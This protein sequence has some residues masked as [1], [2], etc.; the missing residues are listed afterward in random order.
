[1]G[2]AK[3]TDDSRESLTQAG[4]VFGTPEYL[5]PE[6]AMGEEADGRADLYAAGVILYEMLTGNRPYEA[7]SRVEI[8]SMHL[9]RPIPSLPASLRSL[10]RVV[11]QAMAKKRDQRY[12]SA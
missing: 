7:E 11:Q 9:T 3:I 4:V 8:V 12:A 10:E 1:F 2:I 5:S 6:Q